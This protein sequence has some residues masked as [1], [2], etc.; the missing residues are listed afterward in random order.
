M[1]APAIPA[2]AGRKT[3]LAIV[4]AGLGI[5]GAEVVIQRLAQTI[6]RAKF[7]L[8]I[9]CLKVRGSI[10]DDLAREGVEIVV[11]A[12][13]NRKGPDYFTSFK[14]LRFLRQRK[15]DVVHTHTTDALIEVS[16]C[17]LLRPGLKLIHTF[18]FGNY[19]HRAP[20]HM[21]YERIGSKIATHLVAV[22]EV[23][24]QQIMACYKLRGSAIGKVWNG[25]KYEAR[26]D[27]RAFRQKLGL[28]DDQVLIGTL[29][30]LIEQKG[31][32][33]LL[34]VARHFRDDDRVRFVIVGEGKLRQPLEARRAELGL[35]RSVILAGWVADAAEV[36]LPGFDVFFQPSLWEA[37][38]IALLEA[39]IAA[40]PAVTTRVG[41][42][43]YVIDHGQDGLLVD[44]R[45]VP[46]MVAALRQLVDDRGLRER[47]GQVG[48]AK[49][50]N[51]FM[52][53]HMTRAYEAI[54]LGAR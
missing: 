34:E 2:V 38:S 27:G 6:D 15:I 35:D 43:P 5:G 19:P 54:Y 8:V 22:G 18:H 49:A 14:L 10:G 45:D 9:V 52:L 51:Q 26:D 28:R 31:L 4:V 12:D 11:L 30:T 44:A 41:E 25:V 42:A 39:M 37:M 29:A 1:S 20:R 48:S 32:F 21:L 24:R 33:D 16:F 40:K 50:R 47:M 7:N 13:P 36:A 46:G 53:Q 3:N 17:K 23:Q